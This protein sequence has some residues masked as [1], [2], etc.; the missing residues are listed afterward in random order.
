M[1]AGESACLFLGYFVSAEGHVW[2]RMGEVSPGFKHS[3]A[4]DHA[5]VTRQSET[6]W[7]VILVGPQ[8]VS[9]D[10]ESFRQLPGYVQVARVVV[11]SE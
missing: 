10:D 4:S 7:E 8:N 3:C 6:V 11:R 5:L 9:G 1:A 2:L